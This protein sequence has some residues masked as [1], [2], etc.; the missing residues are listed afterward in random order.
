L[1]QGVTPGSEPGGAVVVSQLTTPPQAGFV[2]ESSQVENYGAIELDLWSYSAAIFTATARLIAPRSGAPSVQSPCNGAQ[3]LKHSTRR[4]PCTFGGFPVYGTGTAKGIENVG[5]ALT[6]R[7]AMQ[8]YLAKHKRLR[9]LITITERPSAPAPSST[10]TIP[11]T[12]P[13]KKAA[14]APF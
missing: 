4:R 13:Y 5:F 6:P 1:I 14:A 8:R 9:L 7:P 2:I 3:H 12:V 11:L 10:Q